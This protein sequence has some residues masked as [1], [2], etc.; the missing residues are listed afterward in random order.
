MRLNDVMA[1]P[2][3]QNGGGMFLFSRFCSILGRSIV[4]STIVLYSARLPYGVSI[5]GV[6][7]LLQTLSVMLS[8]IITPWLQHFSNKNVLIISE[9]AGMI[10]L[11]TL[12][13]IG[14]EH[15]ALSISIIGILFYIGS[16]SNITAKSYLVKI[17][18][19]VQVGNSF[20]F[21]GTLLCSAVGPMMAVML[22]NFNHQMPIF[23]ATILYFLATTSMIFVHPLLDHQINNSPFYGYMYTLRSA[24][25]LI[26]Q[27]HLLVILLIATFF[28]AMLASIENLA[29]VFLATEI[30]S[31][32]GYGIAQGALQL[33]LISGAILCSFNI[34]RDKVHWLLLAGLGMLGFAFVGL[35]TTS[36]IVIAAV[37]FFVSGI[38]N[39]FE[40][41]ARE[42]L[43]LDR[44][45][46]Q[47]SIIYSWFGMLSSA[48][49]FISYSLGP[50]FIE[51]TSARFTFATAGVG[52]CMTAVTAG[53]LIWLFGKK[54]LG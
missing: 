25:K 40:L 30:G 21:T 44:G 2:I 16:L 15:T 52:I 13:I 22:M 6:V 14:I 8:P 34:L 48:G 17:F 12:L 54:V 41:M 3:W 29:I 38:G 28:I 49:A 26:I 1:Y 10:I 11:I 50:Q 23:I 18:P 5:V 4:T 46:K 42:A 43:I 39:A 45:K 7:Y 35:A 31:N 51:H 36:S 32:I 19:Q 37:Y 20:L 27:D 24:S 33:G 53:M 9:I 47:A